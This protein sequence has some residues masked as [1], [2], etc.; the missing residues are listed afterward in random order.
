MKISVVSR[1]PP[2]G[3]CTLYMRFADAVADATD[4]RSEVLYPLPVHP[5][6]AEPLPPPP[7]LLIDGRLVSPADGV[8]LSP[9]EISAA[10]VAAGFTGD[11]HALRQTLETE[12]DRMMEESGHE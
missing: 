5:R 6:P 3:R 7:A 11:A 10:A 12:Q 1:Q 4:G 8:I 2:G 9:D